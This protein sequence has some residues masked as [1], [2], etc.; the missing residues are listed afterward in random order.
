MNINTDKIFKSIA[1]SAT[2]AAEEA[3]AAMQSAGKAVADKYDSAKIAL[4]LAH[5]RSEQERIFADIGRAMY[6]INAGACADKDEQVLAARKGIDELLLAAE[7]KQQ[8][9]DSLCDR[10][11]ELANTSICPKCARA[12][13]EHD[14]YCPICG[15]KLDN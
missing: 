10:Q 2:N 15:T 3:K 1:Q 7:Q 8:E 4:E 13:D 5:V 9:I 14:S 11:S 12:C 6:F